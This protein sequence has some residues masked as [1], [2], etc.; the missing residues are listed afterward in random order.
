MVTL[1]CNAINKMATMRNFSLAFGVVAVIREPVKLAL[2]AGHNC[3]CIL[4]T[5]HRKLTITCIVKIR[6]IGTSSANVKNTKSQL[7]IVRRRG[8][9]LLVD[10]VRCK[11]QAASILDG[12]IGIFQ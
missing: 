7:Y 4:Y 2:E 9:A 1:L 10:A 11:P 8:V 12:A 3:I 6:N 5:K